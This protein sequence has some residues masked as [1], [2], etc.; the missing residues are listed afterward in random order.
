V[1]RERAASGRIRAMTR[2]VAA[3]YSKEVF[4]WGGAI[5]VLRCIGTRRR[6]RRIVPRAEKVHEKL[7]GNRLR[8]ERKGDTQQACRQKRRSNN[9]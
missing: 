5:A 3:K 8:N 6:R 1:M 7:S 2:S 9:S 4:E